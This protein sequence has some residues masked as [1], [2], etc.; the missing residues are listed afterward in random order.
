MLAKTGRQAKERRKEHVRSVKEFDTQR[1]E[2][3]RQAAGIS[4]CLR[5][6]KLTVL[7]SEEDW[8]RRIVKEALWTQKL[9]S[10]NRLKHEIGQC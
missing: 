4:H 8:R 7:E 5:L 6:H 10:E 3:A 2:V 9:N 1:S